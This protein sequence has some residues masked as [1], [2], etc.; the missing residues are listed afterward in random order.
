VLQEVATH[1][2]YVT[3]ASQEQAAAYCIARRLHRAVAADR[4]GCATTAVSERSLPRRGTSSERR[5]AMNA[6]PPVRQG[7]EI[8]P[9]AEV[10][11]ESFPLLGRWFTDLHAFGCSPGIILLLRFHL[12]AAGLF[13]LLAVLALPGAYSNYVR[14]YARNTCRSA[15]TLGGAGA[16]A[17]VSWPPL[18]A[19][20]LQRPSMDGWSAADCG[21]AGRPVAASLEPLP[22]EE[23]FSL[24]TCAELGDAGARPTATATDFGG[25]RTVL[26][27]TPHATYCQSEEG[28]T[29]ALLPH[30]CDLIG[31]MWLLYLIEWLESTHRT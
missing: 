7:S 17:D 11:V 31:L 28:S 24:S 6:P 8:C 20:F 18:A 10:S 4:G 27:E 16:G 2:E 23:M 21:Y 12:R 9:A 22:L 5:S 26:I 29:L 14:N 3:P 19:T 15:H 25:L 1:A 13:L 30:W